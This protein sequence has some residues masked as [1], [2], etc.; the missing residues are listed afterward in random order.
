MRISFLIAIF[1]CLSFINVMTAWPFTP[2]LFPE[3]RNNPFSEANDD[4]I[5]LGE[6]TLPNNYSGYANTFGL[7]EQYSGPC[8]ERDLF[9]DDWYT[10]SSNGKIQL[11]KP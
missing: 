11:Q 4:W 8:V 9:N 2:Y 7:H 6:V 1:T 10:Y 3:E 5:F